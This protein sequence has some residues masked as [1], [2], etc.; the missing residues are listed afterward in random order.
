M[1]VFPLK[2]V[3]VTIIVKEKNNCPSEN[4]FACLVIVKGTSA[5]FE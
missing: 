3:S 1:D 4:L 2:D 5:F